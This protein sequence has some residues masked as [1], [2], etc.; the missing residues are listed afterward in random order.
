[1]LLQRVSSSGQS[2]LP[3]PVYPPVAVWSKMRSRLPNASRYGLAVTVILGLFPGCDRPR[4]AAV[5]YEDS[6]RVEPTSP[7]GQAEP[8]RA[9]TLTERCA[10][11]LAENRRIYRSAHEAAA[12]R[13]PGQGSRANRVNDFAD[14]YQRFAT[15]LPS[16]SGVWSFQIQDAAPT[17]AFDDETSPFAAERFGLVDARIALTHLDVAGTVRSLP[18]DGLTFAGPANSQTSRV[19]RANCCTPSEPPDIAHVWMRKVSDYDA[20]GEPELLLAGQL[21]DPSG[22]GYPRRTVMW[23]LMLSPHGIRRLTTPAFRNVGDVDRDGLVD[24]IL[25]LD[26]PIQMVAHAV[27]GGTFSSDDI[28]A[29]RHVAQQC[30]QTCEQLIHPRDVFC[31]RLRGQSKSEVIQRLHA[32]RI[33]F[34]QRVSKMRKR[35]PRGLT[36]PNCHQA[37]AGSPRADLDKHLPSFQ[38]LESAAALDPPFILTSDD[39]YSPR[40]P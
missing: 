12:A 33:E 34:E 39:L 19:E 4:Q 27:A 40:H 7:L 32:D 10:A 15:C 38:K 18:L 31:A 1:M 17:S 37:F 5:R 6:P 14:L 23:L 21:R 20:D 13:L 3:L 36:S 11:L 30:H 26:L 29:R 28:E 35:G 16:A 9:L 22:S 8:A 24:L 2:A 25:D